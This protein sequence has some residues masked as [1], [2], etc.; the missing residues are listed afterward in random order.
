MSFDLCAKPQTCLIRYLLL[1]EITSCPSRPLVNQ[2]GGSQLIEK[3]DFNRKC[4]DSFSSAVLSSK[5]EHA[6]AVPLTSTNTERNF[7]G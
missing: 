2:Q 3:T 4:K 6:D 5:N 1:S 7:S